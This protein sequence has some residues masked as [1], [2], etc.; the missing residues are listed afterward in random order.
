VYEWTNE[1]AL[2]PSPSLSGSPSPM[3]TGKIL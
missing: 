2:K 1:L 3:V